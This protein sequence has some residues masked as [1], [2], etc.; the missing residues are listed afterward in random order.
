MEHCI[1]QAYRQAEQAAL[2][3]TRDIL[4]QHRRI[5]HPVFSSPFLSLYWEIKIRVFFFSKKKNRHFS[6]KIPKW[7]L[8]CV[9]GFSIFPPFFSPAPAGSLLSSTAIPTTTFLL[10]LLAAATICAAMY[11][12]SGVDGFAP[13]QNFGVMTR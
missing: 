2:V 11:A 9:I 5:F 6:E 4:T 1:R 7:R 8:F 10:L 12:R 13:G 3:C